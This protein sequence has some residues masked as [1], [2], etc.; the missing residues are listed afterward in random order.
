MNN[1]EGRISRAIK[2]TVC[3]WGIR[4]YSLPSCLQ[5]CQTLSPTDLFIDTGSAAQSPNPDSIHRGIR[6]DWKTQKACSDAHL[7]KLVHKN[8]PV[9]GMSTKVEEWD[10]D[11]SMADR[12]LS[13]NTVD[14]HSNTA[15]P[16]CHPLNLD[17]PTALKYVMVADIRAHL[18]LLLINECK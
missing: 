7:N 16:H 10:V 4:L 11:H 9:E 1:G 5:P 15:R 2:E 8:T 14:N 13:K 18:I 6:G 17:K 12:E 3:S